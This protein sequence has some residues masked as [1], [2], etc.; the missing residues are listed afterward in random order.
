M[1]LLKA[2]VEPQFLH[3]TRR[4]LKS[5]ALAR[6]FVDIHLGTDDITEWIECCREISIGQI[7]RQVVHK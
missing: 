7:V 5:F 1:F 6:I 2:R 3:Y 4:N